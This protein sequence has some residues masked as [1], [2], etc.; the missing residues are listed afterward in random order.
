MILL[1]CVLLV[2]WVGG[3]LDVSGEELRRK[4]SDDSEATFAP[5]SSC[6]KRCSQTADKENVTTESSTS[7]D[8]VN[9]ACEGPE[10][11]DSA[12]HSPDVP[13]NLPP[14]TVATSASPRETRRQTHGSSEVV[15][16]ICLNTYHTDDDDLDNYQIPGEG[17]A[18]LAQSTI[19]H[20]D[21]FI[22]CCYYLENNMT[23]RMDTSPSGARS[24]KDMYLHTFTK[25]RR[26]S[27]NDYH[28]RAKTA[29]V[30]VRFRGSAFRRLLETGGQQARNL[31]VR[32]ILRVVRSDHYA[33]VRLWCREEDSG[34]IVQPGFIRVVRDLTAALRKANCT[35]GLFL[36]YA[37]RRRPG[38]YANRLRLLDGVFRSP[39]SLLLY[40]T[41][42]ILLRSSLKKW[43]SPSQMV[44]ISGGRHPAG[45][46]WAPSVC[47]L[48]V[49]ATAVSVVL[50]NTTASCS[51]ADEGVSTKA[52]FLSGKELSRLCR[53]WDSSW[54][55]WSH[56]YH[57]VAC[58]GGHGGG[59]NKEALVFQTPLQ[60]WKF[61]REV[62]AH[63]RSSCFGFVD[64][65][66]GFPRTCQFT[67]LSLARP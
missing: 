48:F 24:A 18:S 45:T 25:K 33:G 10:V 9:N 4:A 28:S 27:L 5:P 42:R 51:D 37:N 39:L 19:H 58:P 2:L 49:S 20:C 59:R 11:T 61:R 60:A 1:L 17:R 7:D 26:P 44:V 56:L 8:E 21:V 35:L 32:N 52:T 54:K 57:S 30:A 36:P 62:L 50:S 34:R 31:F 15:G 22:R 63:A 6:G 12:H 41:A 43:T 29:L 55:V 67:S 46:S 40:P 3:Y 38:A 64:D 13:V 65:R 23:L 66:R 53:S 16:D 14:L 47:Y